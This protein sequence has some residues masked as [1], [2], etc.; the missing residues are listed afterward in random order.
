MTQLRRIKSIT[1]KLIKSL[2]ESQK[3]DAI[4]FAR[5]MGF[6]QLVMAF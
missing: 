3:R 1:M 4:S 5:H 2:D 6:Q